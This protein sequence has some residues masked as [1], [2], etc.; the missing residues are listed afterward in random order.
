MKTDNI[1]TYFENLNLE[2]EMAYG[3]ANIARSKSYDPENKVEIPLT[4]NMAER[5]EG[6]IGVIAPQIVGKHI[7]VS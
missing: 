4:K 5:V 1:K 7:P 2:V 3:I 6:L